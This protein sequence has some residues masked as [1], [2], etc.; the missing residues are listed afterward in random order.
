MIEKKDLL[1]HSDLI[2][3][4]V[5]ELIL[6]VDDISAG[7]KPE[8]KELNKDILLYRS[9]LIKSATNIVFNISKNMN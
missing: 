4:K 9:S 8:N 1:K 6:I 7:I 3:N 5:Q 2:Y